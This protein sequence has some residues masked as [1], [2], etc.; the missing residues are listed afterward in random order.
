MIFK[1]N[2]EIVAVFK[3]S[4]NYHSYLSWYTARMA[5]GTL[6]LRGR[7]LGKRKTVAERRRLEERLKIQYYGKEDL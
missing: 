6:L 3:G 5:A 7:I 4:K 1:A 2:K